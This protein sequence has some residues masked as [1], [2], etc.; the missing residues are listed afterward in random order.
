MKIIF[1]LTIMILLVSII[2]SI[3]SFA[4]ENNFFIIGDDS[5]EVYINGE[6]TDIVNSAPASYQSINAYFYED[7]IELLAIKG[8]D[9]TGMATISA[10]R[11]SYL[12]ND[13]Y[14]GTDQTWICY[15]NNG[16][17]PP[18]YIDENKNEIK[19][20]EKGYVGVNWT[21]VTEINP[22]S[23]VSWDTNWNEKDYTKYIW[24]SN[25][26]YTNGKLIDTPVF[27]RNKDFSKG[28]K[29]ISIQKVWKD[30]LDKR[31]VIVDILDQ[32]DEIFKRFISTKKMIFQ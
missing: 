31:E 8:E 1:K 26:E 22:P 20:Y 10:I 24:S 15:T 25:F 14:I 3:F 4:E 29:V 23:T 30:D 28:A 6:E 5:Y 7:K 12:E 18:I 21:P 32:N 16:R 17:E 9:S 27:F 13:A 11:A 2:F 19:W